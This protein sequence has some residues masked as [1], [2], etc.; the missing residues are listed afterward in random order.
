MDMMYQNLFDEIDKYQEIPLKAERYIWKHAELGFREWKTQ[1]YLVD[2]Y[3]SLGYEVHLLG[4]IPGFYI[5]IDTGREGPKVAVFG[6]MDALYI[7]A[8]PEANPENGAVHACGHN[9][10][11]ASLLGIAIGLKAEGILEQL[12]GSIRLFGVPAEESLEEDFLTEMREKGLIRESTGKVEFMRRGLLD[13]VDMAFMIHGSSVVFGLN[14]GCDGDIRKKF[15]FTGK[16][17]H[18]A[19]AIGAYNALYAATNAISNANA[20][21]ETFSEE[22]RTRF[23]PII[24][25]GGDIVNIIPD[26]VEVVAMVRGFTIKNML[27]NNEKINRVFAGAAAGMHCK[28]HIDDDFEHYPRVEDRNLRNAFLAVAKYIWD[29]KDISSGEQSLPSPGVTDMGDVSMIMPVVHA[30]CGK[31]HGGAHS[32]DYLVTDPYNMVINSAKEQAGVLYYLLSNGAEYARKIVRE[33]NCRF[34]SA[35]EYF[36]SRAQYSYRGDAVFYND[37]GTITIKVK[38]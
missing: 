29:E 18:A 6:E 21:R 15:T 20:L 25:K 11:S 14:R 34:S 28:L 30:F 36:E 37:D 4:D 10:Q 17:S 33:K 16:A 9:C 19:G 23:H 32:V 31:A 8:H 35:K 27:V 3:K 26:K 2:I 13:D 5:D 12:S 7:P 24:T 38:N 1:E 22:N